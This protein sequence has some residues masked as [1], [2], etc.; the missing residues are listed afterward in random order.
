M[1]TITP[2]LWFNNNAE[3][4]INFYVSV[5]KNSKI[6]SIARYG[7]Y[8]PEMKGKVLTAV[9]ELNGREFMAIDGGPQFP[10]TEAVS[11]QILCEDQA[12]V[13]DLWNKL[14]ADG[15]S[16]GE[17]GWLKDKFGLSW[18]VVPAALPMLIRNPDPE[19]STRIM[20]AM[21]KMKKIVIKELEDARDQA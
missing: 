19:A 9:F 11:F 16:E 13:D 12:E 5:F 7:D 20:K 4:A 15:G 10:F 8:M 3:E 1:Q 14:T 2:F 21:M 17:C 6:K 18:Q